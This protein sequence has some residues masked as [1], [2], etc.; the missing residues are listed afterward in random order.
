LSRTDPQESTPNTWDQAPLGKPA[1]QVVGDTYGGYGINAALVV[2]KPVAWPF[3]GTSLAAG[4]QLPHV[5]LG[6]YDNYLPGRDSPAN[7]QILA[8]SPLVTSYGHSGSADMTYYTVADGNAGVFATGS[9]GWIPSL[10]PCAATV[11]VCPAAD[12]A[13]ITG[14]VLRLFGTGPAGLA[15]PSIPNWR[16]YYHR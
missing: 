11:A 16:N 8:H 3:A 1:S 10:A 12:V 13:T 2:A 14:N 4:S 15:E 5:V 7:V 6:D 9:I